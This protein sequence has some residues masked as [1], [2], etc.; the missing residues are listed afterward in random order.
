MLGRSSHGAPPK[1]AGS[2]LRRREQER[3]QGADLARQCAH[4]SSETPLDM[5]LSLAGRARQNPSLNPAH[6][7]MVQHSVEC[8]SS[9]SFWSMCPG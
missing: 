8:S 7:L 9:F 3:S 2:S 1:Y 5:A 6:L 4:P